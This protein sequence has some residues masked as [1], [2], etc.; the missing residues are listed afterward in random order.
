LLSKNID[1]SLCIMLNLN[2]FIKLDAV[3]NER[4]N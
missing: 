4:T 2:I 3:T 1:L